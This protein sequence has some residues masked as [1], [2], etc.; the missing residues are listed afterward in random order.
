[1]RARVVQLSLTLACSHAALAADVTWDVSARA[2][3]RVRTPLPGDLGTGLTF[4]L[5]LAP[6]G[7]LLIA[8]DER[9]FALRYTPSF[10]WREPQ[11]GGALL[12]MQRAQ[13]GFTQRWRRATLLLQQEGAWG[14]S[15]VGSLRTPDLGSTGSGTPTVPVGEV[16]TLGG[17]PYLRSNSGAALDV[18]L[19]RQVSAGLFAGYAV[20]GSPDATSALPLQHGPTASGRVRVQLTRADALTTGAQFLS[21]SFSTGQQ[22]L[23]AQL[24]E[25]WE[26]VV[27]RQVSLNAMAGLAV[28]R[29]LIPEGAVGA[30]SFLDV[31][32]VASVG[33]SWQ[34]PQRALTVSGSV[35]MAPFAD[36][37]TA[38]VYERLEA[39]G[40]LDW[41]LS[42]EWAVMGGLT[43]A[44]AV[45]LGTAEQAG[46][47]LASGDASVN[48]S[49]Y[50]WLVLQASM[51]V[52]WTSQPRLD[53]QQVQGVA[54]LSVL[55]REQDSFAW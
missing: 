19:T 7:G 44:W 43:S 1:M 32:P 2:D 5:E 54:T 13:L 49:V 8:G 33:A 45:P 30:G 6:A 23:V 16:Q 12:P 37:F 15:D 18:T 46:D 11:A 14:L 36:R 38:F 42:R 17:T 26:H 55:V 51:R 40:Q 27:S 25:T 3:L 48:W 50:R 39:R 22:Q 20:S 52:V 10:I 53:A 47:A 34:P 21:A 24:T 28:T 41:R 29:E 31:L 35:R 4:D 9:A